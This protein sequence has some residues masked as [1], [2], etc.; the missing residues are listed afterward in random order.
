MSSLS[1]SLLG[2]LAWIDAVVLA[3][4]ALTLTS[5]AYVAWD[6]FVNNPELRIMKWAWVLVTLYTGPLGAVLYVLSC[7]EPRPGTHEH[8][9]T[10]L[11]KQGVGSTMRALA[12]AGAPQRD[13][14]AG[15]HHPTADPAGRRL[16]L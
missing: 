6:A 7:K 16:H 15:G 13:G 3:W 11:W 1:L 9:I 8:F 10:P 2:P 4:I 12:R 5:A 14:R